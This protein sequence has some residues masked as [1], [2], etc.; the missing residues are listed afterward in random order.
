VDV[1]IHAH[2]YNIH[3]YIHTHTHTRM[4]AYVLTYIYTY[5][6]THTHIIYICMY[7]IERVEG[8]EREREKCVQQEK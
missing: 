5:I 1:Y 2:I 4:H 3:T 7:C 6:Y 8:G